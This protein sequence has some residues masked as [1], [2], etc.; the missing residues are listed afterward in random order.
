MVSRWVQAGQSIAN[1]DG[2]SKP[3]VRIT[4][5]KP[6]RAEQ[7]ARIARNKVA[8]PVSEPVEQPRLSKTHRDSLKTRQ[9]HGEYLANDPFRMRKYHAVNRKHRRYRSLRRAGLSTNTRPASTVRRTRNGH[10]RVIQAH[11]AP[12]LG[13][14][15]TTRTLASRMAIDVPIL[16]KPDNFDLDNSELQASV[17][18]LSKGMGE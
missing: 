7:Y 13:I 2:H 18:T 6:T 17:N 8:E 14:D 3:K 1:V 11:V 5:S 9:V 12:E 4:R 16:A 10:T 15:P